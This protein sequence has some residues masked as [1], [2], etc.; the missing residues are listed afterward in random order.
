MLKKT[1]GIIFKSIKYSETSLILD[2]YTEEMGLQK[3]IIS[4]V[5]SQKAKTKAS[6]VQ[7]M[8]LVDL[9]V[10][11]REH[12]ELNRIREVRP[13]YIYTAL[14]F[15]VRRSAVGLFM[16]EIA[17]KT[18]REAEQ[19]P[20][21]F[22][23]LFDSF[24]FLDQTLRPIANL[25]LHFMLEL[26]GLL[27]FL[28]GGDYSNETPYFDLQEGVFQPEKPNHLHFME[29][30]PS[31]WLDK[32]LNLNRSE[33]HRLSLSRKDRSHLL[34]SLLDF[35]RLHIESFPTINAHA[36]LEEVLE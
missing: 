27:G 9:V 6:L 24:T 14:P 26:S 17:R 10:Y 11:Y 5:R 23:F 20:A 15:D 1:R 34:R 13:A 36:I 30:A 33:C 35:Y 22:Q 8:S 12:Q 19:N 25:H 3:Y 16:A 21:L 7:V 4:G 18:I 28:P 29:N 32:L 31:Q 2:I